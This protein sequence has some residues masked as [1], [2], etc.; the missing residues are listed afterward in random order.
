M[1]YPG[2]VSKLAESTLASAA[3]I[4]PKTDLV[5]VTGAAAIVNIKVPPTGSF[6]AVIY[7]VALG[8]FTWTAAGNIAV[9]G[10]STA[11]GTV[12]M[13]VYSKSTGKWYP[14]RVA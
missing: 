8:I 7:L 4:Y 5:R 6:S 2:A 12:V 9:A 10:T 1:A 13:M 14:S 3:T 11:V